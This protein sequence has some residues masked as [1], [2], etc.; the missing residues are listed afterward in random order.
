MRII[1]LILMI[2]LLP[3]ANVFSIALGEI[4]LDSYYNEPLNARIPVVHFDREKVE[5][6][7]IAIANKLAFLSAGIDRPAL[8]EELSFTLKQNTTH[9]KYIHIT[10]TEVQKIL[11]FSSIH[12]TIII[13]K[14]YSPRVK[15]TLQAIAGKN[16]M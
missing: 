6:N 5:I 7:D 4:E 13:Q 14:R 3:A 16:L 9:G 1:N 10:S 2:T 11:P 8:L 12:V 15:L